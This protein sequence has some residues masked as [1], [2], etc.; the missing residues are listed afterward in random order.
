MHNKIIKT[1]IDVAQITSNMSH[2]HHFL[3][4]PIP[5]FPSILIFYHFFFKND[6]IFISLGPGPGARTRIR[7]T[8]LSFFFLFFS[9][10][11]PPHQIEI[12]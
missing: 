8:T 9:G 4:P 5:N 3:V 10:S 7:P 6:F 1:D 2:E 11:Y 12:P